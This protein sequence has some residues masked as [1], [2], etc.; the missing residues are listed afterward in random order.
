M[1]ARSEIRIQLPRTNHPLSYEQ[2][3][4]AAEYFH[5]AVIRRSYIGKDCTGF[6]QFLPVVNPKI[7]VRNSCTI[8]Q[9]LITFT[10]FAAMKTN[11]R[12]IPVKSGDSRL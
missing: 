11:L 8:K 12:Y 5:S 2:T 6:E 10:T 1:E 9:G 4:T 7:I 3:T